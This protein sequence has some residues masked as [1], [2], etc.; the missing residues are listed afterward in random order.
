[1]IIRRRVATWHRDDLRLS[2]ALIDSFASDVDMQASDTFNQYESEKQQH[3]IDD[4]DHPHVVEEYRG[5]DGY[6]FD[7]R[8]LFRDYFPSLQRRSAFLTIWGYF[9]HELNELCSLYKHEKS[10]AVDLSDIAGKGIDRSTK[11]LARVA[12]LNMRQ[13]SQEWR[14][15]K[16]LRALRNAI[17][18]QDGKLLTKKGN[19]SVELITFVDDNSNFLEKDGDNVL[20]KEGFLMF[21]VDAFRSYFGLIAE[22]IKQ[23]ES[24]PQP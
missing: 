11:Y 18:H 7:L 1:M 24:S 22:S 8:S 17:A 6:D 15:I 5:L 12:G 9:E 3:F 20:L 23:R 4:D 14:K 16:Q 10:Y 19:P 21:V 13:D 2:A